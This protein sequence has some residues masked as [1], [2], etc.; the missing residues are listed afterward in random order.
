VNLVAAGFDP[1]ALSDPLYL[2]DD[3]AGTY[4]PLTPAL[5]DAIAAGRLRL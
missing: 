1:R 4:V 3:K 2:R 5:F